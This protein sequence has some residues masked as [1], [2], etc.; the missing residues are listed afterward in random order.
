MTYHEKMTLLENSRVSASEV[1]DHRPF[2]LN[3]GL[4]VHV[5]A[6]VSFSNDVQDQAP[7]RTRTMTQGSKFTTSSLDAHASVAG[8]FS[9]G[10]M[11]RRIIREREI[12]I[13]A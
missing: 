12:E 9:Q 13:E 4:M 8:Q 6:N 7:V 5:K 11:E 2:G 3:S 10:Q 1:I